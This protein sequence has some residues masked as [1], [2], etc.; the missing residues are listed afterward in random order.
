[1]PQLRHQGKHVFGWSL[2]RK[3]NSLCFPLDLINEYHLEKESDIILFTASKTSGGFCISKLDVLK[4]S[5]LSSIITNNPILED[6]EKIGEIIKY[7]GKDYCHLKMTACDYL[8]L[9]DEILNNFNLKNNDKLLLVRGSNIA[10]DCLSKGPLI[11]LANNSDKDIK[12]Y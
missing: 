1:M 3:D 7:K 6:S 5:K 2:I 9:S 8:I 10:F 12:I 4:S 11:N